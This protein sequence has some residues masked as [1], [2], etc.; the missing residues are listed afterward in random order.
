MIKEQAELLHLKDFRI[1]Q[2]EM[3]LA[4]QQQLVHQQKA[5]LNDKD[6]VIAEQNSYIDDL[7]EIIDKKELVIISK[8][9]VIDEK[10]NIIKNQ[11]LKI[12]DLNN[13][14]TSM[15]QHIQNLEEIK[16]QSTHCS[17][18]K[19]S[20]MYNRLKMHHRNSLARCQQYADKIAK[21]E[22]YISNLH[23]TL[24]RNQIF[25]DTFDVTVSYKNFI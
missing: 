8:E 14:I 4:K 17:N 10:I 25:D 7:N 12:F 18:A 1:V 22:E 23:S 21:M 11:K 15:N 2:K 3:E 19:G 13:M 6:V 5:H 20:I 9:D 16:K 24:E